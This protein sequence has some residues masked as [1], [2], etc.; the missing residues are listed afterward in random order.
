MINPKYG[1][2][3]LHLG[4]DRYKRY[5]K[6]P[7]TV[8]PSSTTIS[9]YVEKPSTPKGKNARVSNHHPNIQHYT[10]DGRQPWLT[11]NVSIE[12][13]VPRSK[14]D[15]NVIEH[16][17]NRMQVAQFNRLMLQHINIIPL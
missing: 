12:F 13:I 10:D 9:F 4:F 2:K 3:C 11:D 8:K 15:K 1:V 6:L 17:L 7:V 16:V 5:C 14:E